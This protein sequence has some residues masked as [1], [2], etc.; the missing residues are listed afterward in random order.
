MIKFNFDFLSFKTVFALT[1]VGFHFIPINARFNPNF[2]GFR[3]F[4]LTVTEFKRYK[5]VSTANLTANETSSNQFKSIEINPNKG[6]R[7]NLSANQ[8]QFFG[9]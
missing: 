5:R 1:S 6:Q 7:L 2:I 4:L 9:E 8:I 3:R